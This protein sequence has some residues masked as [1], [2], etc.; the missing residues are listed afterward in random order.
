MRTSFEDLIHN[1][2][3]VFNKLQE[4][5]LKCRPDKCKFG[6]RQIK[7]LGHIVSEKGVRPEP[8]KVEVLRRLKPSSTLKQLQYHLDCY[9][10]FSRYIK[11][12]AS[13]AA[14]SYQKIKKMSNLNSKK[15]IL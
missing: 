6:F 8:D 13:I 14:P 9:N 15:K 2:E 5:K 4:F 11:D 1:M 3:L 7:F 12:F 10:Y